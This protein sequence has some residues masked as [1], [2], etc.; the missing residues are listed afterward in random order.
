MSSLLQSSLQLVERIVADVVLHGAGLRLRGLLIDTG[1]QKKI[2]EKTVFFVGLPRELPALGGEVK[3][4]GLIHREE[5][6][7]FQLLHRDAD[8][9][10]ADLERVR[11]VDAAAD[12][13]LVADA[14]DRFYIVLG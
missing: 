4:F 2:L 8:G 12:F 6:F 7:R 14:Q 3:I 1:I 9:R 10:A 11:N 13:L 5:A